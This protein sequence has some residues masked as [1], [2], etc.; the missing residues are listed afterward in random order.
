ML[1]FKMSSEVDTGILP[2]LKIEKIGHIRIKNVRIIFFF[3]FPEF[4]KFRGQF[5]LFGPYFVNLLDGHLSV[6]RPSGLARGP[7]VVLRR[8]WLSAGVPWL[9]AGVPWLSAGVPWLGAGVPWLIA[10]VPWLGA[11]LP[12]LGAGVRSQLST[13]FR[14]LRL[15]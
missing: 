7:R 3:F 9:G 6:L 2:S 1:A 5:A 11:G 13:W 12:W 8:R 4:L 15:S 14:P 10:G